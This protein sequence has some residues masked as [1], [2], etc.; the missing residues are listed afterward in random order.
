MADSTDTLIPIFSPHANLEVR[1]KCHVWMALLGPSIVKVKG[2]V[3][4]SCDQSQNLI[5]AYRPKTI[6][7][8]MHSYRSQSIHV[9][10]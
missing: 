5:I 6:A 4:Y 10:E 1:T 2:Q 7:L 3:I 8:V 9:V